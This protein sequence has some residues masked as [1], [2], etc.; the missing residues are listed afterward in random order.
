MG[1]TKR[2]KHEMAAATSR[3]LELRLEGASL[4][5]IADELGYKSG[6]TVSTL[7][8][9]AVKDIPRE[10]VEDARQQMV[11]R[12][13]MLWRVAG[14]RAL[15]TGDPGDVQSALRVLERMAKL[16]GLDRTPEDVGP[17]GTVNVVF[18]PQLGVTPM[19]DAA[20]TVQGE[21]VAP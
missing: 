17:S 13:R 5:D 18:S 3:A 16:E 7:I 2:T 15:N 19:L 9:R 14:P 10:S 20:V 1:R 11:E 4:Q 6:A 12:L 21:V 8:R